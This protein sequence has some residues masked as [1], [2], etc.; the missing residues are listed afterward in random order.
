VSDR[1][2]CDQIIEKIA[3]LSSGTTTCRSA[4]D[5]Q[6]LLR[7]EAVDVALIEAATPV[8]V[9]RVPLLATLTE[10]HPEVMFVALL[11][12]DD[13]ERKL[14]VAVAKT[15]VREVIQLGTD[16]IEAVISGLP[17]AGDVERAT[18]SV[19][20]TVS[21]HIPLEA[22]RI[23]RIAIEA[24]PSAMTVT[25]FVIATGVGKSTLARQIGAAGLGTP[26]KVIEWTRVLVAAY[27][28]STTGRSVK[29]VSELLRFPS[30]KAMGKHFGQLLGV[31]PSEFANGR[32]PE[33]ACHAVL[34]RVS[35][36][37]ADRFARADSA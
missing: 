32:D 29:A 13:H 6:A 15:G 16:P 35:R 24:A 10:Q 34:G 18:T 23:V 36:C 28:L 2:S 37:A 9:S 17:V 25:Q 20:R 1:A 21:P 3:P 4:A 19:L 31:R 30:P 27:L 11:R 14:L 5:L 8:G 22:R 7:S 26:A 12:R 33:A